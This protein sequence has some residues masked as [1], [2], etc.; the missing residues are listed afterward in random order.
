[1]ARRRWPAGCRDEIDVH[2]E[3]HEARPDALDRYELD[4]LT[5]QRRE[6]MV[7][8]IDD[9]LNTLTDGVGHEREQYREN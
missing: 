2:K 1:M 6:E 3:L 9:D 4:A 7:E 5:M 8:D